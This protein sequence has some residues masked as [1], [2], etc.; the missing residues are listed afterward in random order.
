[1]RPATPGLRGGWR[2][3]VP[4][5]SVCL[6]LISS[7]GSF[8]AHA[9]EAD[10]ASLTSRI[11]ATED[12]DQLYSLALVALQANRPELAREALERVVGSRP[13]HAGAWLDLALATY[14]S[15]D[16]AAALEHLEYLKSQFVLPPALAVQV[17]YWHRLW[18]DPI[19]NTATLN[20]WQGELT[21]GYG[22][23][24]NA[25]AGLA[26]Q[27][28]ELSL[29]DGSIL[30]DLDPSYLPQ[31]D[32]FGLLSVAVQGPASPYAGGRINP[33]FSLRSKQLD[34]EREFTTLDLQAGLVYQYPAVGDSIWQANIFVQH[35]RLGQHALYNSVRLGAQ[36][37]QPLEATCNWTG[38][39]EIEARQ[40]VRVGKL[41]G[42][43]YSLG[44][45]L[46]CRV[47]GRASFNAMFDAGYEHAPA[48]R[49]GGDNHSTQ[50]QFAYTQPLKDN[51]AFQAAWQWTQTTDQTGY[52]PLLKDNATR[53]IQ[54]HTLT[55]AV[56][57]A[58]SRNW[59]A[60]LNLE[61]FQQ[62]SNLPLFEQ[63][64]RL[65]MFSVA[66]LFN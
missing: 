6:L 43:R 1:M 10:P 40:H 4:L 9:A 36:R 60:R 35:Y 57:Q 26:S 17:A 2:A 38:S 8:R 32:R 39:T 3:L 20:Q 21:L 7:L 29:P 12:P 19:S 61:L 24:S 54:R 25:N 41:S 44:A 62:S 59:Q 55:L 46:G 47:F 15:G 64:G 58:L 37:T 53:S 16:A 34:Q 18:Q 49:P 5:L 51:R 63:R 56:R 52:S 23:D 11:A 22:F 33:M 66:N 31:A 45:G 28:I 14:R 30:F 42:T 27:Q 48:D 65:L 13:R 50:I